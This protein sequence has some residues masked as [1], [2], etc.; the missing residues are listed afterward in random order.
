MIRISGEPFQQNQNWP[1]GS[2]EGIIVQSMQEAS[3]VYSYETIDQLS[4]ELQLRKNI[5]NSANQMNKSNAQFATFENSR[6]NPQYWQLTDT[7]G[8][9]LQQGVN[10]SVAI[11]D[12]FQN[13]SQYAFE[14]AGAMVIIYYHAVLNQIGE[15][16]FNQFFPNIFIYSWHFDADLGIRPT[17]IN[18]FLLGDVVY[19]K[20]PEVAPNTSYW[21][22][23][24]A[25]VMGK[26]LY[27]GHGLGLM[28][29]DQMIQSLNR[30]RIPGANASAYLTNVV[31]RPS[32]KNLYRISMP[33]RESTLRKYQYV[34]IEHNESSIPFDRYRF[35]LNGI[36]NR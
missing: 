32:F 34:V 23:E 15:S 3:M 24:N 33:S 7:G 2:P 8:F 28:T 9:R 14:C 18:S 27:F 4:F 17:Y 35:F 13:G 1:S 10:P 26:D 29:A 19:F 5:M 25:V 31:A 22:G 30:Y 6:C 11:Q 12:I 21:R 20:N 36:Y 16:L